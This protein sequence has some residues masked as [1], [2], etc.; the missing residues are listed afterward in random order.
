MPSSTPNE[1][2]LPPTRRETYVDNLSKALEKG[3]PYRAEIERALREEPAATS[4]RE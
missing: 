4:L 3:T 1:P 2:M